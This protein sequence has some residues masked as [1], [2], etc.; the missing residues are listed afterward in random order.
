MKKTLFFTFLILGIISFYLIPLPISARDVTETFRCYDS[1]Q[2][3]LPEGVKARIGKGSIIRLQYSPDGN[4]L[5]VMSSMG[6]WLYDAHS[7]EE[8][9]LLSG[10]TG[11]ILGMSFSPDSRIIASGGTDGTTRMW[12]IA[13]GKQKHTLTVPRFRIG[14]VSFNSDGKTLASVSVSAMSKRFIGWADPYIQTIG[15]AST[16]SE[17]EL[18]DVATG[19]HKETIETGDLRFNILFSPDGKTLA[20]VYDKNISLWDVTTGKCKQILGGNTSRIRS[21]SFSLDSH[22]FASGSWQEIHVW[23]VAID[24][25]NEIVSIR[26]PRL[27]LK[28]HTSYVNNLS[29]SPDGQTL[30]S[31]S[32]DNTINL[33]D[34]AAGT[35]KHTFTSQ[36]LIRE[37]VEHKV[38]IY[39]VSFSPDTRTLASG[40]IEGSIHLWDL[41]KEHTKHI[42][43]GHTKK[44]ISLTF[45][46]DG[47]VLASVSIDGTLSLWD[48]VTGTQKRTLTARKGT[49]W[50]ISFTPDG[51]PYAAEIDANVIHLWE[52]AKGTRKKVFIGQGA[53]VSN[54]AFSPDGGT[55]ASASVDGTVL[56]WDI[57]SIANAMHST[58]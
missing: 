46:P 38:G 15:I 6:I 32:E 50:S 42:L 11:L 37:H 30:A 27:T 29:F 54:V 18:W 43:T 23:D 36:G 8:R 24:K 53:S 21:M 20:S 17:I 57:A 56:V 9:A 16:R 19:K 34:V 48:V 3:H 44:I 1:P 12:D 5:A 7:G 47:R 49:I 51:R 55:L 28:G 40:N 33:W 39:S 25:Q 10:H 45:S 4:V 22:T 31:G 2:W 52:V 26:H 58:Q 41:T 14:D 13:T 35:H